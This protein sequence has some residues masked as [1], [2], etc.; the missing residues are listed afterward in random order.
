MNKWQGIEWAIGFVI[1]CIVLM[2][3]VIKSGKEA[4]K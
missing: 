4:K 3:W 1:L 2:I